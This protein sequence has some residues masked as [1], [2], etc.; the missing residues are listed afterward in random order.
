LFKGIRISWHHEY[1]LLLA[2]SPKSNNH[3]YHRWQGQL[4]WHLTSKGSFQSCNSIN[5][6]IC[7]SDYNYH[8]EFLTAPSCAGSIYLYMTS[9]SVGSL[10]GTPTRAADDVIIA[11][12]GTCCRHQ[13][14]DGTGRK[15]LHTV[16][17]LYEA[18]I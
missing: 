13:I 11:A 8:I 12:T 4:R 15:A 17:V 5:I 10:A 9:A 16:E 6:F 7:L 18:L 14:K 2:S 1:L 3:Q